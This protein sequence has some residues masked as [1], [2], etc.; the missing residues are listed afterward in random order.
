MSMWLGEII[1]SVVLIV[2]SVIA[3]IVSG[4]IGGNVNP[5]DLGPTAFPRLTLAAV[6]V[7]CI[8]QIVISLK[9]RGQIIKEAK[10]E[11]KVTIDNKLALI[12]VI[13][14]MVVYGLVL[15]IIGFYI[16]SAAFLFLIMLLMGNRKWRQLV[17]IP[18]LFNVFIHV[19]FVMSLG[20]RLP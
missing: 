19:V 13:V 18:I 7:I 17:I 8:S 4:G 5:A 11:K 10:T 6:I 14:L 12:G 20:L 16:A 9:N 3:L 1:I 2:F 15:P